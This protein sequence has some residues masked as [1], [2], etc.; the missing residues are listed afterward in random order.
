MFMALYLPILSTMETFALVWTA[1]QGD[2]LLSIWNRIILWY[3]L[4]LTKDSKIQDIK[5]KYKILYVKKDL[6]YLFKQILVRR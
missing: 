1:S 6:K 5:T 2:D 4:L 3:W